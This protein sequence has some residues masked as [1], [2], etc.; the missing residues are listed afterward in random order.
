MKIPKA[1]YWRA[2]LRRYDLGAVASRWLKRRGKGDTVKGEGRVA[3][4]DRGY[5]H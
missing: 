1:F 4:A 2:D 3:R 5:L